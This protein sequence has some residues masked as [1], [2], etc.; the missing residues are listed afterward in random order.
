MHTF[1]ATVNRHDLNGKE[2]K[3]AQDLLSFVE[4]TF[5]VEPRFR[6]VNSNV[7][8]DNATGN[9]MGTDCVRYEFVE[10]ERGNPIT[11]ET[12]FILTAHGFQCRHPS[13]P[14]VVINAGCSERYPQGEQSIWDESLKQE[15]ESFLRGVVLKPFR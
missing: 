11:P 2:I 6:V 12:V 15:C 14:R 1:Y 8:L 13:S 7:V 9:A 3:S 5:R 4:W 10:E